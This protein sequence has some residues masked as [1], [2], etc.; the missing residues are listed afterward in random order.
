MPRNKSTIIRGTNKLEREGRSIE[1]AVGE[2]TAL[3]LF[4][5]LPLSRNPWR[6]RKRKER[7]KLENPSKRLNIYPRTRE[8]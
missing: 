8:S 4:L 2:T 7:K 3:I 6:I 1:T 5:K